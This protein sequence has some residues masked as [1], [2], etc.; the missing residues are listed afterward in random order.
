MRNTIV[1]TRALLV[2]AL[3]VLVSACGGGNGGGGGTSSPPPSDP[4]TDANPPKTGEPRE[5]VLSGNVAGLDGSGLVLARDDG[6]TLTIDADGRF[7]FT[8]TLT[9]G[10]TYAVRVQA[11]PSGSNELCSVHSGSGTVAGPIAAIR[12]TCV[13]AVAARHPAGPN[14]NDYISASGDAACARTALECFHGGER[15][16]LPLPGLSSCAGVSASDSLSAFTWSCEV[17]GETVRVVSG[18]LAPQMRLSSLIDWSQ[19]QWR[20]ASLTVSLNG[21]TLAVTPATRWWANPIVTANGGGTLSAAGTVYLVE[22][23]PHA[24]FTLNADGV[25]LVVA[26]NLDAHGSAGGGAQVTA[27][28]R[29]FLWLEGSLLAHGKNPALNWSDVRHSVLDHVS[30]SHADAAQPFD[31]LGVHLVD[32]HAN[33]LHAL[34]VS[35]TDGVGLK[36]ERATG[37]RLTEVV[38]SD[39]QRIG[40]QLIDSSDNQLVGTLAAAN[41][42]DG[43]AFR[44][45]GNNLVLDTTAAN[46]GAAGLA[47][48]SSDHNTVGRFAG[49]NNYSSLYLGHASYNTIIDIVSTHNFRH[50][51]VVNDGFGA[52]DSFD[53]YFSGELRIGQNRDTDCL[54]ESPQGGLINTTCTDTGTDGSHSYAGQSS[55]AVLR[56]GASQAATYVGEVH[57][58]DAGNGSDTDGAAEYAPE[59]DW[60]RF[61][62]RYRVWGLDGLA[63]TSLPDESQR[64]PLP[65]CSAERL[66]YEDQASCE[67]NAMGVEPPPQ[68]LTAGRIWDFRLATGDTGYH[69]AAVALNVLAPPSESDV[70]VHL[71][72]DGHSS[73]YLRRAVE[74]FNDARGNDNGLCEA[75]ETCLYTPNLG[76]YQGHG[77]LIGITSLGSVQLLRPRDNGI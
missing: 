6:E 16:A 50:S 2:C 33:R 56:T 62:N 37:N 19:R 68:W 7:E 23:D 60:A 53:N 28:A 22:Q 11:Q 26:P 67:A 40:I 5:Y 49:V 58:D 35:A 61:E 52:G 1:V 72:A 70:A 41:L 32:V 12:V 44:G 42:R 77:P 59:L 30:V 9:D 66:T 48:I 54:G 38:A 15:R 45:G 3:A 14:W 36:L 47:F 21:A 73:T 8:R 65:S 20:A 64:G 39:N 71:W 43:I 10:A 57:S 46:N 17:M 75:G 29:R 74:R 4:S 25:A 13:G 51:V 27:T 76:A 18:G 63:G 24:D 69:G 31:S 34:R 55:D